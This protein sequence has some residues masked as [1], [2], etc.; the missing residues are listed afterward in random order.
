MKVT[1]IGHAKLHYGEEIAQKILEVLEEQINGR[2]VTFYLGCYGSFD[3]IA[4][5]ACTQ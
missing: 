5:Y 1:F 2:D 4:L 3:G